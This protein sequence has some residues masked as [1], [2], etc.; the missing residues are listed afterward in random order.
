MKD[1]ELKRVA[2]VSE[3]RNAKWHRQVDEIATEAF[4][5]AIEE[6][7]RLGIGGEAVDKSYPTQSKEPAV[8][9]ERPT[10]S[11]RDDR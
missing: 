2:T 5:R 11:G 1:G 4:A 3:L 7:R 8:V 6:N 10:D 9:R